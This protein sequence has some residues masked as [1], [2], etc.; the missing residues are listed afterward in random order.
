MKNK[1]TLGMAPLLFVIISGGII[2]CGGDFSVSARSDD[3]TDCDTDGWVFNA[4]YCGDHR[5][6][7]SEVCEIGEKRVCSTFTSESDGQAPCLDDC[8]GWDISACST[9][10]DTKTTGSEKCDGDVT[11]CTFLSE[12]VFP[13]NRGGEFSAGMAYCNPDCHDWDVSRCVYKACPSG[14]LPSY[15]GNA[16]N[17]EKL[18]YCSPECG[19]TECEVEGEVCYL[20]IHPSYCVKRQNDGTYAPSVNSSVCAYQ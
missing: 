13:Y 18:C 19:E 20:L 8:S 7:G 16:I 17:D 6:N 14:G 15:W 5:L 12:S 4:S 10:G 9:C 11:F 3:N 2:S 1:T